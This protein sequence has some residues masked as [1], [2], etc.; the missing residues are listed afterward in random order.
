MNLEE[1]QS[2]IEYCMVA[3]KFCEE[4]LGLPYSNKDMWEDSIKDWNEAIRHWE[5]NL[6][7]KENVQYQS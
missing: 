4:Q 3:K 5:N 6:R 2:E 1:I 7:E